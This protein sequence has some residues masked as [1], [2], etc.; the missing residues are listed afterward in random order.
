MRYVP[1]W[2]CSNDDVNVEMTW[3]H[4]TTESSCSRGVLFRISTALSI[5]KLE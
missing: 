1:S 2:S 3:F 5:M 4:K